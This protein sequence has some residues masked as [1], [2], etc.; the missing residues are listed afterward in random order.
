MRIEELRRSIACDAEGLAMH[1]T[2]RT[3]YPICRSITGDGVRE[4]LAILRRRVPLAVH[5]VPTGTRVFDWTVPREWNIRDAWIIGPDGKK[6]VDFARSNLH[7]MSYSF[8][9]KA[10]LPLA[11][12]K[13][14]IFTDPDRPGLIPYRTSYYR[15]KWAFCMSH[16]ELVRL[17]DGEYEIFIDST[18]ADGSLSY[19]ELLVPGRSDEEVLLSCHV[20]HPSLCNDNLSG[21]ALAARLAERLAGLELRYSYRFLFIPGTIGAITWLSRNERTVERMRHGLVIAC[22]GDS[23]RMTYKRSRR[24]DATIDRAVEH[25]LAHRGAEFE[26]LDFSPDGYD[27]RQYGSPGFDLPVGRL[28]RTPH[29][30]YGEYH[31]SGDDLD[32]V[33]PASLGDSLDAFLAVIDVLENDLVYRSTNPKCEPELGRRGL[34]AETGGARERAREEAAILW[35]LNLSD[36]EHSLLSIAERAALPFEAIRNAAEAL[37]RHGL[38]TMEEEA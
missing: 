29:G 27:E 2:I 26:I 28:T 13:G 20:C 6:V 35:V 9:V 1:E 12:L 37:L 11:E 33:K 16:D 36:G 23:G 21:I 34:Y 30:R 24:G 7:V 8:P 3:L 15:E 5:E 4:T 22:V 14:H 10:R 18:L 31:T 19:G 38:L 17:P 32:L 25:V